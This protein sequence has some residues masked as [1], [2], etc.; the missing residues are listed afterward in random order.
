MRMPAALANRF[1]NARALKAR[2]ECAR[3]QIVVEVDET[4]ETEI[5]RCVGVDNGTTGAAAL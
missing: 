2:G 3:G 1:F 5:E 4:H